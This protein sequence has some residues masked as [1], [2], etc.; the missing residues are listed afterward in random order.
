MNTYIN[1]HTHSELHRRFVQATDPEMLAKK[2]DELR[3]EAARTAGTELRELRIHAKNEKDLAQR[4]LRA[5]RRPGES[6]VCV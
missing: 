3:I 1:T 2:A 6:C 4:K 5:A